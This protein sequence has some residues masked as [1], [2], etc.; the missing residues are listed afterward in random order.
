MNASGT[1]YLIVSDKEKIPSF[2]KVEPEYEKLPLK[3][4]LPEAT[5]WVTLYIGAGKKEKISKMDIV[6]LLLQKG[7]LQKEDLGLIDILDHGSYVAVKKNKIDQL[8]VLIKNA[9]IK[10]QKVKMEVAK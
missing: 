6:G 9:P 10:K 4:T 7:K 5:P 2:L 3:P 1:T 8:L